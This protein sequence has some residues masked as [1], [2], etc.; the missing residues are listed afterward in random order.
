MDDIGA[1]SFRLLVYEI[2]EVVGLWSDDEVAHGIR[3]RHGPCLDLAVEVESLLEVL[4]QFLSM[5]LFRSRLALS[6]GSDL[7]LVRL[8]LWHFILLH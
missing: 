6:S 8:D 2:L 5:L 4:D 1:E 7:R 3:E